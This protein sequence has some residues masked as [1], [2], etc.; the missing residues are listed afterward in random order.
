MGN[1]AKAIS[2]PRARASGYW[3]GQGQM[4]NAKCQMPACGGERGQSQ[5]R[6]WDCGLRIERQQ[7]LTQSRK[8]AKNGGYWVTANGPFRAASM[9]ERVLAQPMPNAKCPPAA[10]NG[11]TPI[12]H[13]GPFGAD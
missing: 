13:T 7:G 12:A 6:I 4:R 2:E 8:G 5:L 10:G 9:S 3:Q 11:G 1:R